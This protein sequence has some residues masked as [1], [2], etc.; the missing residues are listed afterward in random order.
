MTWVRAWA[1]IG[2]RRSMSEE[3]A[4]ANLQTLSVGLEEVR[5]LAS[6]R[7][8]DQGRRYQREGQ[9]ERVVTDGPRATALVSGA[10]T[11][12][13]IVELE[14]DDD[15]ELMVWCDCPNLREP[16]CK[17]AVAAMLALAEGM[18]ET[19]D[20]DS[21]WGEPWRGLDRG[22]QPADL[23]GSGAPDRP[24]P[25]EE[26]EEVGGADLDE[27]PDLERTT[28]EEELQRREERG[29]TERFR[30][31]LRQGGPHLGHYT[32]HSA[33]DRSY[34][35][36]IRDLTEKV[37]HCTCPDFSTNLLGTCKHVEAVLHKLRGS[38]P[39]EFHRAAAEPRAAGLVHVGYE[40][41]EAVLRLRR[42]VQ[43]S[44]ALEA[45]LDRYF[46]SWGRFT[47][48][49]IESWPPFLR[50]IA[51]HGAQLMIGAE[52]KAH[53]ERRRA[54]GEKELRRSRVV[55]EIGR[56]G[57]RLPG[58]RT[59]LYQFQCEGVAFLA[60]QER[61]VLADDM[62]LGKTVQAIAAWEYLRTT[63]DV[64]R[65][66]VICPASVKHQ[67][68]AELERLTGRVPVT[69][70][71]GPAARR[72]IYDD[73]PEDLIV[74]YEAAL[75][76]AERL[77][78]FSPDLLI[79]DE[80]QRIR[81]WRTKT[82]AAVK[83]IPSRF[84]FV[85]T[86]TPLENRLDDLYSILQVVDQGVLGPLWKFNLDHVMRDKEGRIT[87]YR[88]LDALRRRL[89]SVLLRR[90]KAAVEEELPP[91]IVN[92]YHLPLSA[93]QRALMEEG[94]ATAARTAQAARRRP[95]ELEEQRR[96]LAG[97]QAARMAS[98]HA[99]LVDKKTRGCAKLEELARLLQE[100]C[101]DGRHKVLIFTEWEQMCRLVEAEVEQAGLG[102]VVL[103]GAESVSNRKALFAAFREDPAV[104]VCIATDAGGAGLDLQAATWIVNLD[105]PWNP[106][107]REQRLRHAGRSGRRHTTNVINLVTEDSIEERI[108]GI[109]DERRTMFGSTDDR[110]GRLA[111]SPP[112]GSAMDTVVRIVQA[113]VREAGETPGAEDGPSSAG[114]PD[115][116]LIDQAGRILD[117][118][119]EE[120][121]AV[122]SRGPQTSPNLPPP[123]KEDPTDEVC[124]APPDPASGPPSEPSRGP[125]PTGRSAFSVSLDALS[126][127]VGSREL[128]RVGDGQG[129][130][131]LGEPCASMA[132]GS[133]ESDAA[134]RE[135]RS[136]LP[137]LRAPGSLLEGVLCRIGRAPS[138][139]TVLVVEEITDEIESEVESVYG[140]DAALVDRVTVD[141]LARFGSDSPLDG[142]AWEEIPPIQRY[143]ARRV[144]LAEVARRRL[145]A[146]RSLA[147]AGLFVD[148][149]AQAV[150]AIRA[151][152]AGILPP[153]VDP[154]NDLE[155]CAAIWSADRELVPTELLLSMGRAQ[156][157]A[158]A[159]HGTDSPAADRLLQQ[160]LNDA[161][162]ALKALFERMGGQL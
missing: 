55:H 42:P 146:A 27:G 107:T 86:G 76:D 35:V 15:G 114:L 80:A 93:R 60:S 22:H 29:R 19:G 148:A 53:A 66:L 1:R 8:F 123:P 54:D 130:A 67:W 31:R 81:N 121:A 158:R 39:V 119:E 50:E 32:I 118:L 56:A 68:A 52:A 34:E 14:R 162:L 108:E 143:H 33:S 103:A 124:S 17:H 137:E 141:A 149:A 58:V 155:F 7:A 154:E 21:L 90:E 6:T 57:G 49:L 47:R 115:R 16:I 45:V 160:V 131:D 26:A 138:G 96:L 133:W 129:A 72:E 74:G 43:V 30:I 134:A 51:P 97:L 4:M 147:D 161:S 150:N 78:A 75:R 5:D 79:L 28:R 40:G 106:A 71:G 91:R 132:A 104:R 25:A 69:A 102:S 125:G 153:E 83:S 122:R 142:M 88:N 145:T 70:T 159:L 144:R 156:E 36:E 9:V 151:A 157:V 116:E 62:G 65:A 77:Q 18:T 92:S 95:L 128:D 48:D 139:R 10:M 82:A 111:P 140:E 37:N 100:L 98:G 12:P 120:A 11:E 24:G 13:Y 85:L 87:G 135:S 61:A 110:A 46:D 89:Q 99:G 2:P 64:R 63:Q 136:S 152:V 20:P 94:L 117:E 38:A 105:L 127:S 101:V 41:T 73:R 23:S 109:L 44:P 126:D 3:T 112:P 113:L 84:A 59:N